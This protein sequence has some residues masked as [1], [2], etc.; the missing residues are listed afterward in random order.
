MYVPLPPKNHLAITWHGPSY[1]NVIT[2]RYATSNAT[3]IPIRTTIIGDVHACAWIT[4]SKIGNKLIT[5]MIP[6]E[7]VQTAAP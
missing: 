1:R 5:Q 4:R 3:L 7:R 6:A 2:A